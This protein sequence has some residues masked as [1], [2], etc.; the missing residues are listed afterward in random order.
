MV[1]FTQKT[2]D[3]VANVTKTKTHKEICFK[4][5]GLR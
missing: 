1:N 5:L 4:Y 3:L 2:P